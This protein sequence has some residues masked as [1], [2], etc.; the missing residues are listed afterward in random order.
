MRENSIIGPAETHQV[1]QRPSCTFLTKVSKTRLRRS[2]I[3]LGGLHTT[4]VL[5]CL[6]HIPD[7]SRKLVEALPECSGSSSR[8]FWNVPEGSEPSASRARSE[9]FGGVYKARPAYN[10][11]TLSNDLS[12]TSATPSS[13]SPITTYG[14]ASVSSLRPLHS[15]LQ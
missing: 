8:M 1:L 2:S 7:Y 11:V 10:F 15:T 9:Y 4:Y 5:D 6:R 13:N 12:R 3:V 14:T